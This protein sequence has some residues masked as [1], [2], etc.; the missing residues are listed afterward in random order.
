MPIAS[1]TT[2]SAYAEDQQLVGEILQKDRK[3]TAEFV[4]RYSGPVYG[5]VRRRLAYRPE[6][7][8]DVVQEVFLAAWRTL[9]HYR[10]NSALLTWLLGIARHKVDDHHRQRARECAWPEHEDAHELASEPLAETDLDRDT[11]LRRINDTLVGLP[12]HYSLVLVLRYIEER[13]LR[14]IAELLGKTEKS[15]ERTLAR[16]REQFRERWTNAGQRS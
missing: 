6:A 14:A 1:A 15:V 16:A 10:G 11:A 8:E 4:D 3:A 2:A 12:E 5:F 9:G 13:P 7:V